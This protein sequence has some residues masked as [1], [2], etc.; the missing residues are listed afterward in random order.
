MPKH[1][2]GRPRLLGGVIA[3]ALVLVVVIVGVSAAQKGGP[4][5]RP[6]RYAGPVI[7]GRN[8][9][10]SYGSR[11]RGRCVAVDHARINVMRGWGVYTFN[12][13][14]EPVLGPAGRTLLPLRFPPAA[15][16]PGLDAF[17]SGSTRPADLT[18]WQVAGIGRQLPASPA[19]GCAGS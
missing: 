13:G 10:V 15:A 8:G 12:P 11:V 18:Q 3:G 2:A 16:P 17:A 4:P 5:I 9:R 1:L 19:S 6:V 7:P 14:R